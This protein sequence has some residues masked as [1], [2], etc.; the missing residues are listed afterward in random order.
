VGVA[1]RDG[2]EMDLVETRRRWDH[3]ATELPRLAREEAAWLRQVGAEVVLG[4]VP[5]LAFEAASQAGLPSAAQTNFGW[6][7]IYAEWPGFEGAVDRIRDCYARADVLLRLPLHSTA[8]DAFPAFRAIQDV[9]LVARQ[10]RHSRAAVRADLGLSETET[11]VLLSFGGFDAAQLDLVALGEWSWYTFL[12]SRAGGPLDGTSALPPNVRVLPPTQ[13]D[14]VAL[15]AACDVVVTKPGYGIVADCLVT[16]VPV[17]YTD[18]GPFREYPVLVQ[19][20]QGG[21]TARYVPQAD[22]RA[23]HLGPHLD[24]LLAQPKHWLDWPANGAAVVADHVLN[25]GTRCRVSTSL[26]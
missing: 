3:F 17:L 9:P 22:V 8:P 16:R 24:A 2:L 23:G 18:R 13:A 21:G 20:L 19:A 10:P 12:L 5:P 6:D 7:W 4:D 1:Q 11:V 25:L 15:V 14:Y 26:L